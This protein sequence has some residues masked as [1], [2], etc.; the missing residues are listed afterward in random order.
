MNAGQ[1]SVDAFSQTTP[2]ITKI[3][4]AISEYLSIA[5]PA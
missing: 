5:L 4:T 2:E 1:S 3:N